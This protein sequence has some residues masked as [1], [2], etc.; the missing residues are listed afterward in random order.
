MNLII[1]SHDRFEL[2]DDC[3]GSALNQTLPFE[4]ITVSDN[5]AI[6]LRSQ[7]TDK[8]TD[9]VYCGRVRWVSPIGELTSKQHYQ[10]VLDYLVDHTKP[11]VLFHDDDLLDEQYCE[12]VA[13]YFEDRQLAAIA[14]N[15]TVIGKCN[16]SDKLFGFTRR[17][18]AKSVST[19]RALLLAYAGGFIKRPPPFPSYAFAAGVLSDFKLPLITSK[20]GDVEFLAKVL[21]RGEFLWLPRRLIKYRLHG[22]QDSAR[23]S[24]E[25]YSELIVSLAEQRLL[26]PDLELVFNARLCFMLNKNWIAL[27][28]FAWALCRSR[29]FR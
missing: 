2:L 7:L 17:C 13:R 19:H 26:T 4:T 24:K 5:S 15:A 25:D 22:G 16:F 8:S 20:Y 10:F 9:A 12:L 27:T 11:V 3:L 14:S 1:L 23:F 18:F 21:Q 6:A 28:Q 29:F